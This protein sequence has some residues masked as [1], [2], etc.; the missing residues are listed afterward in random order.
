M[1]FKQLYVISGNTALVNDTILAKQAVNDAIRE[2]IAECSWNFIETA[3]QSLP[4][5]QYDYPISYFL[6]RDPLKIHFVKYIFQSGS[7]ILL[8]PM[9]VEEVLALQADPNINTGNTRTFAVAGRERILFY[10]TPASG[11]K[12]I[13]YLSD[14]ID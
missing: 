8:Y 11:D 14:D 4:G 5:V 13:F 2:I 12:A 1:N 9:A 3:P 10:P 6:N 7:A